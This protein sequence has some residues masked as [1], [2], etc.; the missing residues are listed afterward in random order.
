M[1]GEK[2]NQFWKVTWDEGQKKEHLRP[3]IVS[4]FRSEDISCVEK[5]YLPQNTK[6]LKGKK[7]QKGNI[8]K[9]LIVAFFSNEAIYS[10]FFSKK[11][12]EY[13]RWSEKKTYQRWG[14]KHNNFFGNFF[15]NLA[16]FG[17]RLKLVLNAFF[18]LGE[19]TYSFYWRRKFFFFV[20]P[21][22]DVAVANDFRLLQMILTPCKWFCKWL[23]HG[24][25]RRQQLLM[26]FVNDSWF[27]SWVLL[28]A[29]HGQLCT[30][31]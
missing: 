13:Q 30:S 1:W 15:I 25:K 12:T 18:S 16:S 5:H 31:Y 20:R 21:T 17:G 10:T 11:K 3:P 26:S 7:K 8:W 29:T 22:H 4:H 14:E 9:W 28:M 23:T 27:C 19:A 24:F 6:H 2:S